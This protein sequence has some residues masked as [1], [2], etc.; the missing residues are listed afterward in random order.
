MK[1]AKHFLGSK[2]RQEQIKFLE[3]NNQRKGKTNSG[4]TKKVEDDLKY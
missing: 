4:D 1:K 2:E 3:K